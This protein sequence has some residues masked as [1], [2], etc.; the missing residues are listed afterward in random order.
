MT[1]FI[2]ADSYPTLSLAER[3]RRWELVR[4]LQRRH[5]L[6]AVVVFGFGRDVA[7]SYLTNEVKKGGMVLFP[8]DHEPIMIVG[9]VPLERYDAQGSRWERW[10][11]EWHHGP[12]VDV[13]ASIMRERGLER[14]NIGV[15]GLTGRFVGEG[16]GTVS[17]TLW[18][19]VLAALPDVTWVDVAVEYEVLALKKSDEEQVLL[20]K[21]A[22]LGEASCQA[23]VDAS[24]E[25]ESEHAVAAAALHA[26]VA[27]GGWTRSPFMLERAGE[28]MFAWAPPEWFFMGGAPRILHRGDTIAAE[29]FPFYGGI[30]S[31]QQIDVSIGEPSNLLRELEDVCLESLEIGMRVLKPGIR[32]A[33]LTRAME[34]PLARSKTWN[35]GP[36]IQTVSPLFNGETRISPDVDPALADLE[37]LP[38]GVGLDGDFEI[39]VGH[40]FAF[41]PNALRDGQRVCIGGTVLLTE[42]GPEALNDT[43]NRLHVVSR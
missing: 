29:L 19:K 2:P 26:I 22:S 8:A 5:G 33:E 31:Q 41:E 32:F 11:S 7:D 9:D 35:T 1:D 37:H 27:G 17:Y 20:R 21:A 18:N 13:L 42:D 15:V 12:G 25:G 6:D 3:D 4:E 28:S 39:E 16:N 36:M 38:S 24:G 30:E 34:E 14:G 10:V 23:F 40:A 43:P